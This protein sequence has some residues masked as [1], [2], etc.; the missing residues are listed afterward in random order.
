MSGPI[1]RD[2]KIYSPATDLPFEDVSKTSKIDADRQIGTQ[3]VYIADVNGDGL[4]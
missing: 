4:G 1:Y 3:G 2:L